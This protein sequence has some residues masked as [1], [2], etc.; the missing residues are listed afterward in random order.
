[1]SEQEPK[2]GRLANRLGP[3][4]SLDQHKKDNICAVVAMGCNLKTA[5]DFVGV[6]RRTIYAR[7]K[8]EPEFAA[9]LRAARSRGQVSNLSIIAEARK[10]DWKAAAWLLRHCYQEV[11]GCRRT[12][13]ITPEQL[14]VLFGRFTEMLLGEVRDRK[15]RER[16]AVRLE[17][18]TRELS[19]AVEIAKQ[20]GHEA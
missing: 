5:A 20:L 9:A 11:F 3:R 14:G 17:Q 8:A 13:G 1:M 16:I 19:G 4:P 7:A 10:R 12:E 6:S 18:M 15:E 2:P